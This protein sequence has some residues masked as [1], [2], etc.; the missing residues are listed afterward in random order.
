MKIWISS[1]AVALVAATT[2]SGDSA[3]APGSYRCGAPSGQGTAFYQCNIGGIEVQK[4]CAPGTV[5]Y[6][7]GSTILCGFAVNTA[8]Q[9][10][11]ASNSLTVG[12]QCNFVSPYD[13]YMCP[14]ASGQYDYFLRCLA[15]NYVHFACPPG[16]ACVKN[17]GQ[18]MYCGFRSQPA[19]TN[20]SNATSVAPVPPSIP[21]TLPTASLSQLS[22][23]AESSSL[24]ATSSEFG[25]SSASTSIE[26][27]SDL[28]LTTSEPDTASPS[29][30]AT[31]V[32]PGDTST[33]FS[34]LFPTTSADE[35]ATSSSTGDTTSDLL[36][37][38]FPSTT[39]TEA[40][41]STLEESSAELSTGATIGVPSSVE[42]SAN[43]AS[44]IS[45]PA[46]AFGLTGPI[47]SSGLEM[48]LNNG[49]H[50]PF[51]L[52]DISLPAIDLGTVHLPD[53]TYDGIALTAISLPSITIPAFD[54]ASLTQFSYI[55]DLM[56]RAGITFDD[57]AKL[58]I[59]DLSH[60]DLSQLG[61]L[62]P[63]VIMSLIHV[64]RVSIPTEVAA[65]PLAEPLA[66]LQTS[67]HTTTL[68]ANGIEGLLGLSIMT[69]GTQ[70]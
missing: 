39:T 47:I 51:A 31:S 21:A 9:L 49:V 2:I 48:L 54:P 50:L 66:P 14:G 58:P 11:P 60:I 69:Y 29:A 25:A 52:P 30:S 6:T 42:N 59:P 36:S 10:E 17:E 68:D 12:A 8:N 57:L 43:S 7:Q 5:C 56:S 13:E 62:D 55:Q 27:T 4:T 64:N 26:A 24:D 19:D 3:C 28:S 61:N 35:S 20:A 22:S 44:T 40:S 15:G 1:S 63:A 46:P 16:T 23:V 33:D 38:L 32:S 41:T 45:T 67:P 70:K 65:T 18:N 37:D 53:M 34:P